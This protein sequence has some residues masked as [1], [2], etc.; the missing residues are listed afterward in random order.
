MTDDSYVY[1]SEMKL[2]ITLLF[3]ISDSHKY[4]IIWTENSDMIDSFISEIL[5]YESS[6]IVSSTE[7]PWAALFTPI[8][9]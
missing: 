6:V 5:K 9:Q 3:I 4:E 8:E 1:I 2:L 7:R